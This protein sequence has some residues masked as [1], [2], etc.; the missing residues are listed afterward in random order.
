MALCSNQA[1]QSVDHGGQ[2]ADEH[3]YMTYIHIL[4]KQQFNIVERTADHTIICT[5]CESYLRPLQS[6]VFAV[7]K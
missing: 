6:G 3:I 2:T 7:S 4:H 5:G 1:M